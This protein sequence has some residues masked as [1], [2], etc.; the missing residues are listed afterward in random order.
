LNSR[1]EER[2]E[3]NVPGVVVIESLEL[4]LDDGSFNHAAV[5]LQ[6]FRSL[7]QK[8]EKVDPSRMKREEK[9][10]FWINIHNALTMHVSKQ[11]LVS[12]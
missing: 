11:E 3:A 4:H 1:H 12:Y 2:K 9:L 7:V 8:L 6:N 10:A 5:M